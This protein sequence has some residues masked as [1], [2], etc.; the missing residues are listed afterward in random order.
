MTIELISE[1]VR[2]FTN[3]ESTVKAL[4]VKAPDDLLQVLAAKAPGDESTVCGEKVSFPSG[5]ITGKPDKLLWAL[6]TSTDL[7]L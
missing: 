7:P 1:L 6:A 5:E 3:D 2:K 4:V